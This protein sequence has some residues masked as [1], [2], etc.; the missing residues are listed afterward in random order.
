MDSHPQTEHGES[1]SM[2]RPHLPTTEIANVF[3]IHHDAHRRHHVLEY[4]TGPWFR[5]SDFFPPML[6][7]VLE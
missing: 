1:V 4:C 7:C 6:E 3:E 2:D 5:A